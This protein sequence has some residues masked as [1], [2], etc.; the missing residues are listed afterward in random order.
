MLHQLLER[1]DLRGR[2]PSALLE[3][4]VL[5]RTGGGSSG[6]LSDQSRLFVKE[7]GPGVESI[8]LLMCAASAG[9]SGLTKLLIDCGEHAHYSSSAQAWKTCP[10]GQLV[11]ADAA[12]IGC[13]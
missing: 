8:D 2:L 11:Q 3:H 10:C 1:M 5:E 12:L 4:V 9:S 6:S 13:S 7:P